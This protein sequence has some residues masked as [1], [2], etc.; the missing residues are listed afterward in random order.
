[1]TPQEVEV[2]ALSLFEL[3]LAV[4]VNLSADD[5]QYDLQYISEKLTKCASAMETVGDHQMKLAQLELATIRTAALARSAAQGMKHDESDASDAKRKEVREWDTA[6]Q[7]VKKV[8]ES[9]DGKMQ[10]IRRLDSDV[11]QHQ[12]MLELK[13]A[14]GATTLTYKGGKLKERQL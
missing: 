8:R 13:V 10:L 14:A 7:V 1:M 5:T 6:E 4:E 3:T 2:K 11:R 12:K 9:M